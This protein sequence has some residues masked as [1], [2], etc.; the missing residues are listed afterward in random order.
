MSF[1]DKARKILRE[2]KEDTCEKS[3]TNE[4]VLLPFFDLDGGLVIPFGCDPRFHY[5][6][7]GQIIKKTEEEVRRILH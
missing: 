1:A 6:N 4:E 7:G 2:M 5:W 3:V